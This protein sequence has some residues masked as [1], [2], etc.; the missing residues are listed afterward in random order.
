MAV[1]VAGEEGFFVFLKSIVCERL[2]DTVDG[3][4]NKMLVVNTGED[5]G[6]DF[7]GLEKMVEV[8]TRV[9]FTTFTVTVGHKRSEIVGK[10][11]VFDVNTAIVGVEGA[12]SRHAGGADAVESIATKFGTD[13]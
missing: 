1:V 5:L 2:A 6:G 11:G 3:V 8:G 10:F 12:I 9:I 4:D 13:E 7:V